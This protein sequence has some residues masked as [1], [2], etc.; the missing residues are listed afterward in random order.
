MAGPVP[1]ISCPLWHISAN[2]QEAADTRPA[3]SGAYRIGLLQQ[4][5]SMV[6]HAGSM[7]LRVDPLSAVNQSM[8][9]KWCSGLGEGPR[10]Q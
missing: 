2:R 9:A 1:A 5:I 10:L 8:P 7:V 3:V 6:L 4:K